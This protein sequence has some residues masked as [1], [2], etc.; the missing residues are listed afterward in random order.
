MQGFLSAFTEGV[1]PKSYAT[2]RLGLGC[3]GGLAGGLCLAPLIVSWR[4]Q[5]KCSGRGVEGLTSRHGHLCVPFSAILEISE[6]A[7]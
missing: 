3:S 2:P 5:T 7:L 4:G 1:M 6:V